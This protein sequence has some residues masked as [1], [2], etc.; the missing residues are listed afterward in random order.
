MTKNDFVKP[1]FI[2]PEIEERSSM[3]ETTSF[4]G[5]EEKNPS[6]GRGEAQLE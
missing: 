1:V 4:T 6:R 2:E 3:W 5:E